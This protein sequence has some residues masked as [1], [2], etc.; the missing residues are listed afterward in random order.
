MNKISQ[1]KP[2]G[3][4][5]FRLYVTGNEPHSV[6]AEENLRKFCASLTKEFHEIEIVDVLKSYKLAI[7]NKILLTPALVILSPEPEATL[8]GDLRDKDELFRILGLGED[9]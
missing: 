7:E 4:K 3:K 6:R 9:K 2:S 8:Y 5:V 1:E